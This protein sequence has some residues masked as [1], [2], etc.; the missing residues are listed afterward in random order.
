VLERVAV[1]VSFDVRRARR[2]GY[3][4]LYGTV[5]PAEVGALVGFQLLTPGK[6]VNEGGTVVKAGTASVSSFSRIV[7]LRHRGLYRALVKINDGAHVSNYSTPILV[8]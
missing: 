4:R 1:R 8:R 2:R 5:A 7:R 6:S 3:V